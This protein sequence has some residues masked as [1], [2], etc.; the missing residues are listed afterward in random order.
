MNERL[1]LDRSMR[2]KDQDGRLHVANCRLSKA[3]VNPY[4]GREIPQS[5]QLGLDPERIYQL[6]RAPDELS[7]A[8]ASSSGAR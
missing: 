2:H 7:A 4:R 6:Y 8:A 3:T 5:Q 1:A